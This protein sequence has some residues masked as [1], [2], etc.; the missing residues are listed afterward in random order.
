MGENVDLKKEVDISFSI[1]FVECEECGEE[2]KFSVNVDDYGD[3]QIT[4]T[5]HTCEQE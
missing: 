5:P 1:D 2:L 4:V 3:L